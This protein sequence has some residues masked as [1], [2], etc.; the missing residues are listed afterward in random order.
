[1]YMGSYWVYSSYVE[2]V[3]ILLMLFSL[4]PPPTHPEAGWRTVWFRNEFHYSR[5]CE[6]HL[7]GGLTRKMWCY[8][9]SRSLEYVYS[10]SE[11]KHT[12]SSNLHW[13]WPC[14]KSAWA[15]WKSWQYDSR[16]DFLYTV[17]RMWRNEVWFLV[18]FSYLITFT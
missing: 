3:L 7:H 1:M 13:S 4:P 15:N 18:Y 11:E 2:E 9:P 8:L 14:W 10:H 12:K 6:Y 17:Q 5:R 16:Y